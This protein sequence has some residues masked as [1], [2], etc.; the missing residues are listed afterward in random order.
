MSPLTVPHDLFLFF[1]KNAAPFFGKAS[2]GWRQQWCSEI[3]Y[4]RYEF[5]QLLAG[6]YF[7]T[8]IHLYF[9]S[10]FILQF[11]FKLRRRDYSAGRV[12][13]SCIPNVVDLIYEAAMPCKLRITSN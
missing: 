5:C 6:V 13:H 3:G 11:R 12:L 2:V 9:L 7:S 8:G 10:N 4:S 1:L